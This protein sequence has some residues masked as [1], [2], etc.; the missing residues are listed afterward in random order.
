MRGLVLEGGGAKGAFH[1]GAVKALYDNGYTFDGVAG[2]SIGAINGALIVQDCGYES[3]Y[4]LWTNINASDITDLNN[5]EIGKL[6]NKEFSKESIGYWVKTVHNVVSNAGIPTDK[7]I[8]FLKGV[9]S[10]KKVRLS[11]MDYAI[12]TYCLSDRSQMELFKEDIPQGEL[13]NYIM[14]SAYYPAFRMNKLNDRYF[15]DGGIFN[16]LPLNL[17]PQKNKEYNEIFAIRT[18][19]KMPH[20][21][22]GRKDVAVHYICPSEDLGKAINIDKKFI[23]FKIKMGYYD[24]IAYLR[25]YHGARYYIK[26][27]VDIFER[28]FLPN[29]DWTRMFIRQVIGEKYDGAP[30]EIKKVLQK[31]W[32][33]RSKVDNEI[34]LGFFEEVA[35]LFGVEKFR[36]YTD[37][38]FLAEL[39][40]QATDEKKD[41]IK[42]SKNEKKVK[43]FTILQSRIT[44]ALHGTL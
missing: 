7:V 37:R 42:G 22:T 28:I 10:E 16:N 21:E 35:A 14:A 32:K 40:Q 20:K 11:P 17:L 38:T 23:N 33:I 13:H 34:F 41:K 15:F 26:G 29:D 25:G 12:A 1:C 18:M 2:T 30:E 43:L 9:I 19:S 4:D 8:T 36:I 5:I 44:E 6:I 3:M 27:N 39:L 24:T 31:E